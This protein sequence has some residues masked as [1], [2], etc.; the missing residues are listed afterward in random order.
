VDVDCGQDTCSGE[1]VGCRV[2]AAPAHPPNPRRLSRINPPPLVS[3]KY[4]EIP[5]KGDDECDALR[6]PSFDEAMFPFPRLCG[7]IIDINPIATALLRAL[8][9]TSSPVTRTAR[10]GVHTKSRGRRNPSGTEE[11][12]KRHRPES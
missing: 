12:Q 2:G 10:R 5:A 6:S 7:R 9:T 1:S 11:E 4:A 8:P 3:R